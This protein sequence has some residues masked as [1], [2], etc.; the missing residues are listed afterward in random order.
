MNAVEK[1]NGS[2][3]YFS[4]DVT[5]KSNQNLVGPS[6]ISES[7]MVENTNLTCM[8]TNLTISTRA[9]LLSQGLKISIVLDQQITRWKNHI[10][11]M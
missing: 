6:P 8:K 10:S 9:L 2:K 11:E 7:C 4:D 3:E 5:L 1:E